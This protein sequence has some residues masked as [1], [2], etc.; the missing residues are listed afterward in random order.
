MKSRILSALVVTTLQLAANAALAQQT[1]G[2]DICP[3]VGTATTS[4]GATAVD[5][6]PLNPVDGFPEFVVDSRGVAVQR[7]LDPVVCFFDPIVPTDPLSLQIGSGGE[8]FYWSADAIVTDAVGNRVLSMGMAAETAFLQTGP[9]GEPINGSQFPFLRLRFVL[10]V[11]AD[12]TYTIRHPYGA[13]VFTVTGATGAR[14]VFATVDKGFAPNSKGVIG[15]VGPFLISDRAPNGFLGDANGLP[16][17]VTGSPCGRNFVEVSGV[18]TLG[19]PIDFGG[20][21]FVL[22]TEEFVVQGQ[23][24]DGQVQTPLNPTRLTYSRSAD[25]SGQIETFAE[26]TATALVTAD[27]GPT[28]PL[29]ARRYNGIT[30][31][32]SAAV[33]VG[34]GIDSL[35]MPVVDASQLPPVVQLTASDRR[36]TPAT[37]ATSLNLHIVDF[38]DVA[39]ADY[40]PDTRMLTVSARTGD[41]LAHPTLTLRGFGNFAPGAT[42][43]TVPNLTAPPAYV[44]VD[45]AGGGSDAA[46]VMVHAPEQLAAPTDFAVNPS[47]VS[48]RAATLVW[49]DNS[50]SEAGYRVYGTPDGGAQQLLMTVPANSTS[51]RV[52]GLNPATNYTM[53]V[54][55]FNLAA[56]TAAAPISVTTLALPLAPGNV[57]AALGT[58]TRTIDVTWASSLDPQITS[59]VVYRSDNFGTP[60]AGAENLPPTATTFRDAN[61]P[62]GASVSYRVVANRNLGGAVDSS[63]PTDSLTL[64][65]PALPTA[66]TSLAT[67]LTE[68]TIDLSWTASAGASSYQVFRR[69]GTGAFVAVG[70]VLPGTATSFTDANLPGGNYSYRVVAT[71][72]AGTATSTDTAPVTVV[73]LVAASAATA[74]TA[75]PPVVAWTDNSAGESA[76]RVRRI[77]YTVNDTTGEISAAAPVVASGTIAAAAGTG[78]RMT[79]TDTGAT[80]NRTYRYDIAAMNGTVAGP[81]ATTGFTVSIT[82]GLP[83]PGTPVA[84]VT[85]GTTTAQVALRWTALTNVSVGGYEVL[86][87]RAATAGVPLCAIGSPLTKLTGTATVT[88][89][90]VDGRLTTAF[91]DTTAQR[92]TAYVYSLRAVGGG[93]TGLAGAPSL[94]GVAV[95]VR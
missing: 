89:G 46:P 10:G 25:G 78:T 76:Y 86:R 35:A 27:D 74:S 92:N 59:Y 65:T 20:G 15:P 77:A 68:T 41:Q 93:G 29:A 58:S 6:G 56:A 57:N 72:W 75:N 61:A 64:V 53:V 8:A 84:T 43:I 62:V 45:S 37:D 17:P 70:G 23:R 82:G 95:T 48:S 90:T 2:G 1:T 51:A 91:T 26:S 22:R 60:L 49:S 7:C 87:C 66:P 54:E 69:L 4:T 67:N 38:V 16:T 12:G 39:T 55:A 31:L 36:A 94:S 42:S 52:T 80:V 32:D 18:D 81:L 73:A 85:L 24:Y 14:D 9:N 5:T 13:D 44:Y 83:R 30:E 71:N 11:P 40:D 3:L 79:F 88:A 21:V 34:G 28:T 47:L 50:N 19:Q 63:V 33:S